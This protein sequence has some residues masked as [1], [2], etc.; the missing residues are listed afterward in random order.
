MF[1]QIAASCASPQWRQLQLRY[2]WSTWSLSFDSMSIKRA[3]ALAA[4]FQSLI[5]VSACATGF[6]EVDRSLPMPSGW[7]VKPNNECMFI[8]G[9]YKNVGVSTGGD[10][11]GMVSYRLDAALGRA[12][13]PPFEPSQV[14]ISYDAANK[15]L[16]IE[17]LGNEEPYSFS[18]VA[19]CDDGWLTWE[20]QLKDMYI[21][22]G[23]RVEE[24]VSKVRLR[25]STDSALVVHAS[26]TAVYSTMFVVPDKEITESWSKYDRYVPEK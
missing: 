1:N 22:D 17:Y 23:V 11:A 7:T 10:K 13:P 5:W 14:S 18:V 24:S 8:H 20:E 16:L 4:V 6:H 15:R 19:A 9:T 21:A 25:E 3:T 2:L 12:V 26:G